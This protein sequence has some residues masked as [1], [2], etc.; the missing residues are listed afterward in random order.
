[1]TVPLRSLPNDHGV[2]SAKTDKDQP[3]RAATSDT[4][5]T[6][7]KIVEPATRK[8]KKGKE[9]PTKAKTKKLNATPTLELD[10]ALLA[11]LSA[12]AAAQGYQPEEVVELLVRYWV[13]N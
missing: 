5:R 12:K 1:M 9:K 4:L 11:D 2:K 8:S 13:D 10:T 6:P 3:K 7:S